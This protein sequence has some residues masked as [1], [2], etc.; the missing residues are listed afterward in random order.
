MLRYFGE[1]AMFHDAAHAIEV[2]ANSNT[3]GFFI[4]MIVAM[5]GL[6][7]ICKGV[8]TYLHI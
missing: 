2:P 7:T 3:A 5:L 1:L 6:Y 8:A 4:G